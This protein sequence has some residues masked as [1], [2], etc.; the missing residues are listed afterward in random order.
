VARAI[1]RTAARRDFIIHYAYLLEHAGID[2]A[3][4]FREAVEETYAT[5]AEMPG[6]GTPG[7]RQGKHTGVRIF[8]V[9]TFANYL[10]V[11]RSHTVGVAIERLVH[12]RQ[13]Y[14]RVLK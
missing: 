8:P 10:V 12:A 6:M 7:K 3:K 14:Q 9:R 11:Y 1:Q 5:L 13:D 2:S 4:R